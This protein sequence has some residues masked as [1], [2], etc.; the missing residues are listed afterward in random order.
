[1]A[2]I[3]LIL[4]L[5]AII[6]GFALPKKGELGDLSGA[7]RLVKVFG[8]SLL[9]IGAFF[10]SYRS[11]P[12]GSR[13]IL[14][15]FGAVAGVLGE[16]A[17]FI[18][19]FTQSVTLMEVRTQKEEARASAAS[20]DLQI[21]QAN[22]AIN[23]HV[24]PAAA[25]E[26][27]K[28]VGPD[29]AKRIIDPATQETVKAVVANYTAEELVR[30]RG[31]VKAKIDE[32]LTARLAKYNLVVEAGGVSLTNF[33]FSEEYNKAIERKQVAQQTAEQQ[34]YELQ[35]AELAAKTAVAEAKGKAEAARIEAEALNTQGGS[36]VLTKLWL[37]RWDGKLP[38]LGGPGGGGMIVDVR[39]L[40][41]AS[42][43]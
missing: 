5:V 13:G 12:A 6:A 24:S 32:G 20:R 33:D 23:Y 16:G 40:L 28:K 31:D 18:V 37:E 2:T 25:G 1:M 42:G 4:A 8:F 14:L 7:K 30:L 41:E 39:S 29:Y 9:V 22:I 3:I 15:Q 38:L 43:K 10:S 26:L 35:R 17:H 27:F 11:V 21:V 36:K 19:P 34:K